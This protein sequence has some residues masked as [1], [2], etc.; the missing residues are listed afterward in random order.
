MERAAT[1]PTDVK[2]LHFMLDEQRQLIE[3]L[4][5]NLHRLLKW[6][7]GP[8]SE[9]INVDQL[10][11]FVDGSVVIE[12]PAPPATAHVERGVTPAANGE[13]RRAVRVLR[14]LPRVI[15]EIDVPEAQKTCPCCGDVMSRF[16]HEASEQLHYPPAKLEVHEL[17]RLKYACTHCHGAV[18]RAPATVLPPIPKSMA[19]ASLLAYLIVSKFADGLPLYRIAGRLRRLGI[20]LTHTLM[21]EWLMLCYPLLE[22]LHRRMIRKVLDSGHVYTDD[23]TLPLQNHDPTRRQLY[24]AKLW[25][26]AKDNRHGPPLIV[27]EFSKSR[28]RDAP[29][30]FLADYR[31]YLQADAYPGYDPLFLD[32]KITEVACNVHA[33]RRFVEAAELLEKPGR[34]HEAL[35][36]YKQLFRVERQIKHLSD[37]E[38]LRERQD[39]SVPLLAQF[40]AWLDNAVHSVLPKDSLGQAIHYALKHWTALTRFTEAGHLDASNNYAERCMRP[41]AVGRKAFLSVGSE[42][43]G[44]AAAIYY[45]MVESCKAN[46][47]NPLTYLTYI[48]THARD[49]S[50]T[51]PTPDEFTVHSTA[52]AGGCA[53]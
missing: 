25:V 19:S 30:T 40:K 9:I 23:T 46:K 45:S 47:V 36:F 16:G 11:L 38:R 13:R 2:T 44:H 28:T 27:Y 41:V 8:R 18:V 14:N 53:L 10:G 50:I 17:R 6:Q 5:A 52:P 26:Y 48:L 7:F 33:R 1:Y 21:S 4:K 12:V 31:G 51:L 22:D 3:S 49:K 39:K 32:G 29:L 20:E 15:D 37:E 43:A 24:Q 35:A 34:P 42:R